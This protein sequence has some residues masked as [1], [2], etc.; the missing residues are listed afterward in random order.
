[1]L[2][3]RII[4]ALVGVPLII[5]AIHMGGLVY[6][7][8]IGGVIA[9]C[10]YEYGLIMKAGRKPVHLFSLVFFGLLM[11]VVAILGRAN[12][13]VTLPDNL[14]PFAISVV[15]FGVMFVEV[16]TPNRSI[17][18]VAFTFFGI[19]F[20]PW[21]LAH[22]INVRDIPQ[23]GE[24]LTIIMIVTVWV[25]DTMAYF[26]GRAFGRHKMNK[27]VS[28]KKSWEGAI[29]GTAFAVL[30]AIGLRAL[31]LP[32]LLTVWEA[33]LLGLIIAVTGQIS[34]LSESI[35]KRSTGVKDSSNLLPGHGGFLDRFDSYLLL[36][37]AFYYTVLF[38]L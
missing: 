3:P 13:P 37:P 10:L 17:E 16:I 11:A 25:C 36:A 1:M 28:P 31:F 20:I 34:D 18:R 24:Y 32:T 9:L 27:E 15:I 4:T 19:F 5:A 23:Y 22:M 14:Y 33:A 35:I 12:V 6:M 2:L 26:T 30:A 29:G 7:A 38:F 8:F 21:T